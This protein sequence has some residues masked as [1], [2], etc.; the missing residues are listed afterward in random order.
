MRRRS[1]L[2][3]IM[4]LLA[5]A[6]RAQEMMY[7][8]TSRVGVPF[9][10]DPVVVRFGGRYL[11]YYSI[12]PRKGEEGAGWNIGIAQSSDLTE[13]ERIGELTPE[14][15][16]ERRGLCAPGA[17]V[18]DDT[19]HLFYQTY[20]NGRRD[21]ICHA[22]STDGRPS[23][24]TRRTPSSSPR[25][26]GIAVGPSMP[27]YAILAAGTCCTLPRATPPSSARCW[28]WPWHPRAP[29]SAAGDGRWP[30]RRA[31][32]SPSCPGNRSA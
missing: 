27:R 2:L 1:L 29:T 30:A 4:M 21:A 18:R 26:A 23:V 8:D 12:P 5:L 13:W 24:A 32:W 3:G 19:L 9:A 10:K 15:E 6:G 25:A 22:W 17:L 28:A 20:G 14:Q 11:M 16:C 31:Y 7:R